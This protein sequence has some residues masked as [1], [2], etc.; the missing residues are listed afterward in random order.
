MLSSI[1]YVP[2]ALL[3]SPLTWS[4]WGPF[5]FQT[6]RIL[7]YALYF[8]AGTIIG[9][10]A[11]GRPLLSHDGPLARH[12]ILWLN[13]A[14]IA[15]IIALIPATLSV[16]HPV[17]PRSLDIGAGVALATSCAASNFAFFSL[18]LHFFRSRCPIWQSLS[19][20]SYGIYL[21]HY[22]IVNWL[23]HAVLSWDFSGRAKGIAVTLCG[24]ALSWSLVAILRQTRIVAR[25]I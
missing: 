13:A 2:M 20:S 10:S 8:A 4:A 9:A 17:H 5:T 18:F 25:I 3:F 22:P 11:G 14:I 21:V 23:Q 12:W 1:A 19:S 6:S 7:L 24:L 15:F 16:Q